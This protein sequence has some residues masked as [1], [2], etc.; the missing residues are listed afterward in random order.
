MIRRSVETVATSNADDAA[1]QALEDV[2]RITEHLEDVRVVGGHMASLL[3]T[4]FPVAGAIIRRTADADAA[5]STSIAASGQIHRALTAAG[6]VA[7]S[8]N[9]YAKGPLAI[10]LLVPSGTNEFVNVEHGGRGFDAAPGLMR[11]FAMEPIFLDVGVMLTDGSRHEFAVRV[12][13]VEIA[14][15]LKAYATTSRAAPKDLTDL[16]NLLSV[17]N[18]YDEDR[19]GAWT[20]NGHLQGT[21]LDSGRILHN[22]A[23]SAQTSALI[24]EAGIPQERLAALIRKLVT[25]PR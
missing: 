14:V 8:G 23:D 24:R 10:D 1:Y 18:S 2:V 25:D 19:I 9:H 7:A 5:I 11:A 13:S 15:T 4:A 17:A 16:Y 12:P 6:Y 22:I 3:L 21:R 20:L